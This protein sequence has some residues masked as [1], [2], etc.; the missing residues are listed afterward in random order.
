MKAGDGDSF[1][2][3]S[4]NRKVK[5]PRPK[6]YTNAHNVIS[7]YKGSSPITIKQTPTPPKL[8]LNLRPKMCNIPNIYNRFN[9]GGKR[10]IT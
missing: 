10:D 4:D 3:V 9:I 1:L 8:E 7:K 2:T 6:F 5:I